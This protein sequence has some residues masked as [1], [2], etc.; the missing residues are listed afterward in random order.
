MTTLM[1]N[2]FKLIAIDIDGTLRTDS[3]S[4]NSNTK[5]ILNKCRQLGAKVVVATGR[6][7]MSALTYLDDFIDIDFLISFQGALIT[8]K[9]SDTT[10]WSRHISYENIKNSILELRNYNVQIILYSGNDIYVDNVTP[11]IISYAERNKVKMISVEDLLALDLP[12]YRILAVGDE[13]II[14]NLEEIMKN[15]YSSNI[16]ATRSLPD[17]CEILNKES[18][19]DKALEWICE[20][21]G[22]SNN[23]VVAFGNGFNDVEMLA[24]SGF[25]VAMPDSEKEAINSAD[26]LIETSVPEYLEFLIKSNKIG[27]DIV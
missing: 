2:K 6:S 23:Q 3:N 17:F 12:T 7:Y 8:E 20:K 4:D 22:F 15:K 24:W 16:Y 21:M 26:V 11:W 27:D 9:L 25:G 13:L 19:K 10:L 18:G 14:K 5:S 1:N